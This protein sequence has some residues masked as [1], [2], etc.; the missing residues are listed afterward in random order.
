MNSTIWGN[1]I[2]LEMVALK[3]LEHEYTTIAKKTKTLSFGKYVIP[4]LLSTPFI[5]TLAA[6]YDIK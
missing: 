5:D 6:I 4:G 2:N 1:V 3:L